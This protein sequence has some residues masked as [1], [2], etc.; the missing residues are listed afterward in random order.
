MKIIFIIFIIFVLNASSV[1]FSEEEKKF[2]KNH[3]I[4]NIGID[5]KWYTLDAIDNNGEHV[6]ISSDYLKIISKESGLEFNLVAYD[7]FISTIQ[8]LE[9][10]KIDMISSIFKTKDRANHMIFTNP[11][12]SVPFYI[13]TKSTAPIIANLNSMNKNKVCVLKGYMIE[14][15]LKQNY[16]SINVIEVYS[17]VDGL[18]RVF[19]GEVSAFIND[20]PSTDYMLNNIFLPNIK[21][22]AP[23]V[24]LS[25]VPIVMAIKPEYEI[26][27]SIINKIN[28]NLSENDVEMLREKW[29]SNSKISMLNFSKKEKNWIDKHKEIIFSG[30]PD[31][32]PFEGYD[33][34]TMQFYGIANDILSIISQRTGIKFKLSQASTWEAAKQQ[35]IDKKS[36]MLPTIS[37]DKELK[38]YLNFSMPYMNINSI[39]YGVD[40]SFEPSSIKELSGKRVAIIKSSNIYDEI[41]KN[42]KRIVVVGV[43][44]VSD[45]VTLLIKKKVDYFITNEATALYVINSGDII[46]IV[47]LLKLEMNYS[48]SI[49]IS[50]DLGLDG[51]SVINKAIES[52]SEREMKDIY[53]KWI[54]VE[55]NEDNIDIKYLIFTFIFLILVF[56]FSRKLFQR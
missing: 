40:G 17:I 49:A 55:K 52:I 2:I 48:P 46:D 13:Y 56:M 29:F 6:G 20:Y 41:R 8:S 19:R 22:N 47:G 10:K 14:D 18:E 37:K 51:V 31:W 9:E 54:F 42:H 3:P 53:D 21:L 28:S 44:S 38:E 36:Q 15:W 12:I 23:V 39:V 4:I 5:A 43:D 11:Y 33:S 16:P 26:L 30:D 27:Q 7:N 32:L 50:K 35:I 34:S 24:Q 25:N 45:L 1:N